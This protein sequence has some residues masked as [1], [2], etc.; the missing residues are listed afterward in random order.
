MF[1]RFLLPIVILLL[2]G[3]GGDDSGGGGGGDA[4]ALNETVVVQHADL[5]TPGNPKTS[6]AITPTAVRKGTQ[7]ELEDAGFSLDPEEKNTTP[8]YVDVKFENKGPQTITN[9]LFVSLEDDQGGSISSTTIID[10]GGKPFEQCPQTKPG[11][12]LE[13]GDTVES[14]RLFLVPNGRTPE[15]VSFLPNNPEKETDFVYWNVK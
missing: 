1:R 2:A 13:D 6:L 4:H 11:G 3:C 7:A 9:S 8:Y 14:C 10:L 5:N 12:K 15:Q